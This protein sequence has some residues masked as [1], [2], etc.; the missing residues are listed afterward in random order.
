MTLHYADLVAMLSRLG[1]DDDASTFHGALCGALC[2]LPPEDID[3]VDLLDEIDAPPDAR[4]RVELARV[5]DEALA[6]LSDSE[7]SFS[8]LLPEDE[9][10][11]GERARA[12]GAWCEGFLYG[13]AGSAKLDIEGCS[14]EVQEIIKDFSQFTRANFAGADDLETEESAYA[15]LIEYIRI[16]A[17]LIYIELRP[18]GSTAADARPT[19]H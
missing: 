11:L 10:A 3:P 4:G 2:R 15:E 13:L 5:M 1:Y 9:T 16:G 17:Q 18:R 12:L 7:A 19:L 6:S 8:P 14:E